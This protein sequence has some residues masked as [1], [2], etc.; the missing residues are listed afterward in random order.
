[1]HVEHLSVADYRSYPAADLALAPGVTVLLGANGHG[2][3]NL[4][5]AVHYVATLA[6]H[7]VAL[8]AP[9]VRRG[10]ER[11][12]IRA[13]IR[14]GE[15]SA[16]TD[17]EISTGSGVRVQINRVA[18]PRPRRSPGL[19]RVVTFAPEDLAVVRGDPEGRRRFLDELLVTR[20]P[21]FAGVRLDYER[22][23]RQRSALL[24]SARA[25]SSAARPGVTATLDVW[26]A[27]LAESG[28]DLL[29]GRLEVLAALTP[30]LRGAYAEVSGQPGAADV[31]YVAR[32]LGGGD[33]PDDGGGVAGRDED[34]GQGR[35]D[36]VAVGAAAAESPDREA[37]RQALLAA[38]AGRRQDEIDRGSSLVGPHRDDVL[39]QIGGMPVRGYASH[40]ESWSMALSLRLGAFDLLRS[41]GEIDAEPVLIL[42]D[43]FAELDSQRRGHLARRAAT[44]EQALI[45]A[46]VAADVPDLLTGATFHV[47]RDPKTGDSAISPGPQ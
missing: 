15:R 14:R 26:D 16:T 35:P 5:E 38:A 24:K 7:R 23:V 6:S 22:I 9:L 10:A 45:S 18:V 33:G 40:G 28:A 27:H 46:A 37:L 34:R 1:V 36:E 29:C 42:D 8:D 21:R 2:K 30:F 39:L 11:A 47:S 31:S 20:S 25:A 43:V 4:L 12:V 41:D 17:V 44:A 13:R 32:G 19:L 3:T